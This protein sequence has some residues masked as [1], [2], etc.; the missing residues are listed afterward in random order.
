MFTEESDP[1]KDLDI[2]Y[3]G[4]CRYL[5]K[6]MG[7]I[8]LNESQS[9]QER[10]LFHD[11]D[12]WNDTKIKTAADFDWLEPWLLNK[13]G[14]ASI[15]IAQFGN[16]FVINKN[17]YFHRTRDYRGN[18]EDLFEVLTYWHEK[19]RKWHQKKHWRDIE[20][21]GHTYI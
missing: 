11:P 21:V 8:L 5:L 13:T 1:V 17:I 20:G 14:A 2:G 4:G 16:E 12:I 7:G 3:L 18:V 15:V 10:K 9:E 6:K 19:K